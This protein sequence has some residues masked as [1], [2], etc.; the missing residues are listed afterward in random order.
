MAFS[1]ACF[2]IAIICTILS[3]N[4]LVVRGAR[5]SAE[6]CAK[7]CKTKQEYLLGERV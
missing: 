6:S 5:D 1:S 4:V 3:L 2:G 7:F